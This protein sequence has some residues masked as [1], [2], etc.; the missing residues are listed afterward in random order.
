MK[1]P[2]VSVLLGVLNQE[3]YLPACIESVLAQTFSDFEFII[4]NDG[5][6][7]RTWE[8]IQDYAK[9]DSRI[10]PYSFPEKQGIQ[11]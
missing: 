4:L 3:S 1:H 5:S 11:T 9:K 10:R 7:D 6:S 2:K 8:I